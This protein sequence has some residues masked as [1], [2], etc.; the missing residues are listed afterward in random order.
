M[1]RTEVLTKFLNRQSAHTPFRD[2]PDGYYI[3]RGCTLSTNGTILV[4]YKTEI[5]Y[6]TSNIHGV[7][8]HIN[9]SKYSITTSHIQ[10]ELLRLATAQCKNLTITFYEGK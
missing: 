5:A 6:F 7:I 9:K 3:Y 4:N 10:A 1:T 8:L 2:I